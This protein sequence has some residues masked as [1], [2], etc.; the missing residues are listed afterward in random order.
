[1][2]FIIIIFC[3]VLVSCI[4]IQCYDFT[5]LQSIEVGAPL[6]K[7]YG[8]HWLCPPVNSECQISKII[9]KKLNSLKHLVRTTVAE[10]HN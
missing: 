5:S 9:V 4:D 7:K 8:V 10:S 3:N 2:D 6:T 1:M